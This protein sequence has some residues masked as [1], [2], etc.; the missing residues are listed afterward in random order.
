MITPSEKL[1]LNKLLLGWSNKRIGESLGITEKTVKFHITNIL[2]EELCKT[3]YELMEKYKTSHSSKEEL[4]IMRDI[5][6]GK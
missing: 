4:C 5:I 2:A 3:R 1:V 6:F